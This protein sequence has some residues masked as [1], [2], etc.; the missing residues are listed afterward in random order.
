MS[1]TRPSLFARRRRSEAAILGESGFVL[2]FVMLAGLILIM[3]AI[4]LV[5]R[6]TSG[7]TT[8]AQ[9]SRTQ[10]ARMAAET[11]FNEMMAQINTI[12]TANLPIGTENT[13]PGAP[14]TSYTI[15]SFNPVSPPNC[16]PNNDVGDNINISILGKLTTGS[17]VYSQEITR[18]IRVCKPIASPTKLRV[19][20]YS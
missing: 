14:T 19:R 20:S 4:S 12:D 11:G 13:I 6:T 7:S 15:L 10:A 9:E 18:T 1:L 3:T 2:V 17:N 8:S 16:D 5:S